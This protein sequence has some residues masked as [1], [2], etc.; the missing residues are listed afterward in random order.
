[1]LALVERLVSLT[2]RR[3]TQATFDV[4]I[5]HHAQAQPPYEEP[6]SRLLRL[7]RAFGVGLFYPLIYQ[8]LHPDKKFSEPKKIAIREDRRMAIFA[9]SIHFIPVAATAIICGLNLSGYYIG[10]EL[11]GIHNEDDEKFIGLQF[12]AKLHELTI[13]ASL[14][15]IMFSFVRYQLALSGGLPF[16]AL[17][18]G[19]QFQEI[20]FLWSME[21]WGAIRAHY[22]RRR[23]RLAVILL[24]VVC[25]FLSVSVG[26]AS[27]T[28]MRPRLDTW[29]AGGTDFWVGIPQAEFLST[30]VTSSQVPDSCLIDN[31]D[32]SCPYA[33]WQTI[34]Q[35]YLSYYLGQ[36]KAG[37][38]PLG[39]YIQG[40]KAVRYL[41][42]QPRVDSPGAERLCVATVPS[43]SVGDALI[44]LAY[45]YRVAA[46]LVRGEGKWRFWSRQSEQQT[47]AAYQPIVHARCLQVN[48][49][50]YGTSTSSQYHIDNGTIPFYS[51]ADLEYYNQT[52]DFP[53]INVPVTD[54]FHT[55]LQN[56]NTSSV[57]QI[58]WATVPQQSIDNP[59]DPHDGPASDPTLGAMLSIPANANYDA[60]IYICTIDSRIAPASVTSLAQAVVGGEPDT[61]W[62]L[63]TYGANNTYPRILIDYE[64]AKYLNPVATP[65]NSTAI[66]SMLNIANLWDVDQVDDLEDA[67]HKVES[68]L[69]TLIANGLSRRDYGREL[70]GSLVGDPDGL[71]TA[72]PTLAEWAKQM[73]PSHGRAMGPGGNAF[74]VTSSDQQNSTKFTM[75]TTVSGYAYSSQGFAA[76]FSMF[77]LLLHALLG[78]S[79]WIY[80]TW[81]K[82]SSSSWDSI[83]ELVALAMNSRRSEVFENTGAGIDDADL[84]KNQTRVV[85]REGHLELVVGN[86]PA[87]GTPV[88]ANDVYG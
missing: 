53:T 16:G 18:T 41:T 88:K 81:S 38:F 28:L 1:M 2:G 57:P 40:A 72:S 63:A 50:S 37:Y 56:A 10:G 11:A 32:P 7:C 59:N 21:L 9:G 13:N 48:A 60:M 70:A 22:M 8:K 82:Q 71:N 34:A 67:Q 83:A 62:N 85:Q 4:Q 66:Q 17:F 31:G 30:N 20:S 80:M 5:F 55:L 47:V 69:A 15:A 61:W 84:F 27:A 46:Q 42:A 6:R 65:D 77:V 3:P 33:D 78:V 44:E 76:Q 87:G 25:A 54:E 24:V 51:L 35:S 43:S 86:S 19:L 58:A 49:S 73:M 45:L 64:W 23:I 26:S 14:T 75:Y 36:S 39:L 74:S 29:P 79:H 52:G 68:L 12:G